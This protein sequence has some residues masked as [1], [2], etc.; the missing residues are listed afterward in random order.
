MNGK[1]TILHKIVME[2]CDAGSLAAMINRLNKP[3]NEEQIAAAMCM[4]QFLFLHGICF[5]S[6]AFAFAAVAVHW[7][8]PDS[9]GCADSVSCGLAYLHRH[10]LIHRDIKADNVLLNS[11]GEAKL[12]G[13]QREFLCFILFS[14]CGTTAT[15]RTYNRNRTT[16]D[17]GVVAQL[18]GTLDQ[19]RT[20]TGTPYW[21]APELVQEQQYGTKV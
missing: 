15:A 12:G 9:F 18:A 21:M 2:F 3:L 6:L 14:F 16:A 20:A 13:R 1:L 11:K 7:L 17:M 5:L 4:L 8:R 19:R 10:K